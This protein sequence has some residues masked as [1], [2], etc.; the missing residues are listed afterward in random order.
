MDKVAAEREIARLMRCPN[1][2]QGGHWFL[3][4]IASRLIESGAAFLW[5]VDVADGTDREL[6]VLPEWTTIS[7]SGHYCYVR[8][9]DEQLI[10]IPATSV[11][12]I[13]EY[14]IG[15]L[16]QAVLEILREWL[17]Q[18]AEAA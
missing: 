10:S 3:Q 15:D 7:S 17:L 8:S 18:P 14:R 5:L 12:L 4:S 6:Y 2:D 16:R 1:E 11:K 13:D 9:H